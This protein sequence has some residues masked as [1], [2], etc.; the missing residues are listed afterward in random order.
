MNKSEAINELA[1]ALSKAQGVIQDAKK[2]SSNPFFKSKYADLASVWNVCRK[3]LSDNGLS[4]VQTVETKE[5]K[6]IV[7]TILLHSSG[8]YISSSLELALKDESMQAIGSAITYARRYCLSA[9]VG[10]CP[11]DD[12]GEESMGRNKPSDNVPSG[13][14]APMPARPVPVVN[15]SPEKQAVKDEGKA[16][17]LPQNINEFNARCKA[18]AINIK[19]AYPILNIKSY[20]EITDFPGSWDKVQ[21]YIESKTKKQEAV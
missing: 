14:A 8:Q 16:E 2:D 10:I 18:A 19:D 20:T 9:I 15:P 7:E 5:G 3:P 21:K 12:D 4:I 13:K 1:A 11:D 6:R 17:L